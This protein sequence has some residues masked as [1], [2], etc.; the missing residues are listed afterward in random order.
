MKP[1]YNPCLPTPEMM[2]LVAAVK[3]SSAE[4]MRN[5]GKKPKYVYVSYDWLSRVSFPMASEIA[6]KTVIL[7]HELKGKSLYCRD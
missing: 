1:Q 5:H 6:G 3:S 2:E 4:F 7:D